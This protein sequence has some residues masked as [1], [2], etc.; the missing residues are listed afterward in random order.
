MSRFQPRII[1]NNPEKTIPDSIIEQFFLVL[2][3]GDLDKIRQFV[4]DNKIKW[5]L[6]EKT[7]R[8]N[9]GETRNTP[10]HVILEDKSTNNSEKLK[11][12]KYL[13]SMGA[14]MD[15]PDNADVWPIHL[16]ASLQSNKITDF[17]IQNKV[18]L[19]RKD[20][21]NNTPLHYAVYGRAIDC[22]KDL[23]IK[24]LIPKPE[25]GKMNLNKSL[26][27][28]NSKLIKLLNNRADLNDNLIHMINTIMKIPEMYA[29]QKL[30]FSL[31]NDIINVF[32]NVATNENFSSGQTGTSGIGAM[33]TQQNNL[34]KVIS[35]TYD[36]IREDLFRD[37]IEPMKIAPGSGGWGPDI[38]TGPNTSRGPNTTERI[39]ETERINLR[40]DIETEYNNARNNIFAINTAN[41]NRLIRTDLPKLARDTRNF[42]D[43]LIFNPF[44][45]ASDLGEEVGLMK[46]LCLL[47]INS[48]TRTRYVD[49]LADKIL[50]SYKLMDI[51]LFHE[52]FYGNNFPKALSNDKSGNLFRAR[53]NYILNTDPV[54]N[55]NSLDT[56]LAGIITYYD[57]RFPTRRYNDCIRNGLLEFFTVSDDPG[58][59]INVRTD[60]ALGTTRIGELLRNPIF[61]SLVSD[62]DAV[63]APYHRL[64]LTWFN[65]LRAFIQNRDPT[66]SRNRNDPPGTNRNDVFHP[67]GGGADLPNTPLTN[68]QGIQPGGPVNTY[69]YLELFRIMQ[70]LLSFLIRND[71][72]GTIYPAIFARNINDWLNYIDSLKTLTVNR[73]V[74]RGT[75]GDSFPVFIFLY[76][77]LALSAID[78]IRNLIIFCAQKVIDETQ[79]EVRPFPQP[80]SEFRDLFERYSNLFQHNDTS[81]LNLLYPSEPA[82]NTFAALNI[83]SL[84]ALKTNIWIRGNN[85][86]DWFETY[87]RTIPND[88][89]NTVLNGMLRNTRVF[90]TAITEQLRYRSLNTIRQAIEGVVAANF[91]QFRRI[92]NDPNFRN[93]IKGY[94]GSGYVTDIPSSNIRGVYFEILPEVILIDQFDRNIAKLR[95]APKTISDTLFLTETYGY[96]YATARISIR[97]MNDIIRTISRII[98]DILAFINNRI[99]Y[100]I[101][102]IFLPALVKQMTIVVS[103]IISMSNDIVDFRTRISEFYSLIDFTD[104]IAANIYAQTN[105]TPTTQQN[106]QRSDFLEMMTAQF[107]TLYTGVISII[108]YHNNVIDFLNMNSAYRLINSTRTGALT[109]TNRMFDMNLIPFET[110]PNIMENRDWNSIMNSIRTYAIPNI[111]YYADGTESTRIRYDIFNP[112]ESTANNFVYETYWNIIP[113]ARSGIISNAPVADSNSQLNIEIING[114]LNP[115]YTIR[116]INSSISGQWLNFNVDNVSRSTY[117]DGFISYRNRNYSYQ[118]LNGMPPSIKRLIGPHFRILKQR[119]IEEVIQVI[120]DNYALDPTN[121]VRDADLV[122]LYDNLSNLSTETTH[123]AISD[124]KIYVII[125]KLVDAIINKLFEYAVR[126][127]ISNWIYSFSSTNP[128]YSNLTNVINRTI[129][130]IRE[131]NNLKFSLSDVDVPSIEEILRTDPRFVDYRLSQIEKN[132]LNLKYMTKPINTSFVHYLYDINYFS[133][134]NINSNKECYKIKPNIIEKFITSDTINSQNSDGNTPLSIAVSMLYPDIVDVLVARGAKM[135]SFANVL[136]KTPYDIATESIIKHVNYANGRNTLTYTVFDTIENFVLPF[137]DLLIA[138]LLD[139][140]FNNNITKNI[141]LGIPVALVIYNHMFHLYLENYRYGFS[142]ELKKSIRDIIKKYY[143]QNEIIYPID[144]FEIN[145]N[146]DLLEIMEPSN[147]VIRSRVSVSR[148]NSK[149]VQEKQGE[150]SFLQ[151]QIDSLTKEKST[152]TDPDQIRFID[153]ILTR[154]ENERNAKEAVV[155]SLYVQRTPRPGTSAA[156]TSIYQLSLE[157]IRNAVIDRNY[158]ILDFYKYAFSQI[159]TSSDIHQGIWANYLNKKLFEAPSMI[160]SVLSEV[161]FDIMDIGQTSG[162][163]NEMKT[164][165]DSISQIFDKVKAYID[166][167]TAY[168]SNFEDNIILMEEANQLSYLIN[169]VI[170]PT[171]MNIVLSNIYTGLRDMDATNTITNDTSR[172]FNE[173]LGTQFNGQTIETFMKNV[174]PKVAFKHY[175]G[176]YYNDADTDKKITTG[177]DLFTPLIEIIKQN[178]I[179]QVTDDSPLVSNFR[180]YMIPF[181]ESTYHNFIH[182]VRLATYGYE[183]YLLNTY[184]MA[185]I[186]KTIV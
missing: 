63:R 46:M 41:I 141:T 4:T 42:L 91:T 144:L 105:S 101:P 44:T 116:E 5:N 132:P 166:L 176:I 174:L 56:E 167:R 115:T 94:L 21:S 1:I 126:S 3:T 31:Q 74:G 25:I 153:S 66:P 80:I 89:F 158:D 40:R 123:T 177:N 17:L 161:I 52:I 48:E 90:P 64:D 127:S 118:W 139:D 114:T 142:I 34:E 131:K 137:N 85:L 55:L 75:I 73:N 149:K 179:I 81:I 159:G 69:T 172:I 186:L 59:H 51:P 39:L 86:F 133:D 92:V 96:L 104:Q 184:K 23:R 106:Q 70:M 36:T 154:L 77:M 28:A 38:P 151:N 50:S 113:Y 112:T 111:N 128:S 79:T 76:K 67:N 120:I 140:R 57:A 155:T 169:L 9:P 185:R 72:E 148:S 181:M 78:D 119:I 10:F 171:M 19:D 58:N 143:R 13:A 117:L 65:L 68:D 53:F 60:T 136:G 54:F 170:T 6:I 146:A 164:E 7:S 82:P 102:Q 47:I 29:N 145:S 16:A 61:D 109:Q 182:H 18:R 124:V 62:F 98:T 32:T 108:E 97:N 95:S 27:D 100:Y 180:E 134:G 43:R 150:I 160:F 178:R 24:A 121:A 168:P 84:N 71:F 20:A 130:I 110:I 157:N 12:M 147:S 125:G 175:T 2:K 156:L 15:L 49:L 162:F 83:P 30:E 103:T 35:D 26:E 37:V 93:A 138:R 122:N 173:I 99:L 22:P 11:I 165:L 14:P 135:K 87:R 45:I 8:N 163:T 129:D 152:T 107:T 183:R 88:F 33:S